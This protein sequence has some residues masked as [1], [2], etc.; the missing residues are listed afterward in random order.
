MAVD[1]MKMGPRHPKS[2]AFWEKLMPAKK[3]EKMTLPQMRELVAQE[4][5]HIPRRPRETQSMLRAFYQMTRM[6]SLGKKAVTKNDR[7][8]VM[9]ECLD[10]LAENYPDVKPLY[11]KAFFGDCGTTA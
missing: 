11:D 9:K 6:N 3:K 8:A 7:T 2:L 10:R 1:K 4:M 5:D